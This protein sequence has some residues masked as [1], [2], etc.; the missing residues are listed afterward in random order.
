M[1]LSENGG[2]G[3]WLSGS[4][5]SPTFLPYTYINAMQKYFCKTMKYKKMNDGIFNFY[6]STVNIFLQVP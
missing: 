5:V 4:N 1:E 3:W 6:A 2:D